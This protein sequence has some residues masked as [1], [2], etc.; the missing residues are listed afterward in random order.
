QAVSGWTINLYD[1]SGEL[2][3]TDVTDASGQYLFEGL[4]PGAYSVVEE[5][6]SGWDSDYSNTIEF[7][8]ESGENEINNNFV[9]WRYAS[10][11]GMKF[12]DL[13]ANG[14]KDQ[15]DPALAGWTIQLWDASGTVLLETAVTDASGQY[16]FDDL[17][18]GEYTVREVLQD[19]WVQTAPDTLV[20]AGDGDGLDGDWRVVLS[21]GTDATDKDFGNW[22][23]GVCGLTPGFWGQ[24]LWA[25]DGV[26]STDGPVDRQGRSLASKLVEDGV[27]SYEDVLIPVD[28]DRNGVIN[29][30]DVKGVLVGD[31]N[32]NGYSDINETT[33]F[34]TLKDAQTLIKSSTNLVNADQRAKMARDA[35]ASQLNLLNGATTAQCVN[36]M[37][38]GAALWMTG[39][40]P[41]HAFSGKK[42][43]G[44]TGDLD[45]NND[46]RVDLLYNGQGV[47]TGIAGAQVDASFPAWQQQ[48]MYQGV[49]LSAS[50]IH[51]VLDD[52]NNCYLCTG[53]DGMTG[54]GL[55]A[56]LAGDGNDSNFND[57]RV[58][59]VGRLNNM[60]QFVGIANLV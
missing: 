35:I 47:F 48:K 19:G 4:R 15:G 36:D 40:S 16:L 58:L 24:H 8:L 45:L 44:V 55:V 49:M 43:A 42:N 22:M 3:G 14:V 52:F 25:W 54:A 31:V 28:S 29:G 30:S 12:N 17:R 10:I 13:S 5:M 50:Q 38:T 1:A 18:P 2:I 51:E 57:D 23:P 33:I 6:K 59:A 46:G 34:F 9:N 21:S 27:L 32:R 39:A 26:A 41:Y 53:M 37:I 60:Q 7:S 11:S 20:E 56:A